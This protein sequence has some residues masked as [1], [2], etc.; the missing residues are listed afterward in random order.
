MQWSSKANTGSNETRSSHFTEKIIKT[1][2]DEEPQD[3]SVFHVIDNLSE[4]SDNVKN[5]EEKF[6]E[7]T[8]HEDTVIDVRGV[9]RKVEHKIVDVEYS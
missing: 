2:A 8:Q 4:I 3:E 1:L 9:K 6:S 7:V 5:E